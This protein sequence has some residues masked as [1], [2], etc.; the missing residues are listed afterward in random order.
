[1]KEEIF[2]KIV[3]KN[4]GLL[5][6]IIILSFSIILLLGCNVKTAYN[7]LDW[8]I[9]WLVN[10][11]FPLNDEQNTLLDSQ[12]ETILEWHRRTQIPVYV[13]TL[14]ETI[15]DVEYGL[16][17]ENLDYV[18][19][20]FKIFMEDFTVHVTPDIITF[21]ETLTDD[22]LNILFN[23]LEKKNEEYKSEMVDPSEY[24]IRQ[25]SFKDIKKNLIRIFGSINEN[26]ERIIRN[27]SLQQKLIGEDELAEKIKWQ[28]QFKNTLNLRN[29]PVLFESAF[30]Y[31]LGY[32]ESVR[33]ESYQEKM[34]YNTKLMQDTFL[35]LDYTMTDDQREFLVSEMTKIADQLEE[36]INE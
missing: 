34:D 10:N 17:N 18:F 21:L 24:E 20:L 16:S 4:P 26:Q 8:L 25:N 15:Y 1:M 3:I 28:T 13:N 22:Q 6:K 12:L 35:I 9:P 7:Q 33:P 5:I 36:L 2:V 11:Y 14:R 31:L 32:N 27:W 29:N 19:N 30:I 23:R